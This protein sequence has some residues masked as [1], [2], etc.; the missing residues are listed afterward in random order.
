MKHTHYPTIYHIVIP[1]YI[2][3]IT[4]YKTPILINLYMVASGAVFTAIFC[5]MLVHFYPYIYH[6]TETAH[7]YIAQVTPL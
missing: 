6:S 1:L 4:A 2:V 5:Y 7:N 3:T